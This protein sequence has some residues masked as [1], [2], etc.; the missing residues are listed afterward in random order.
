MFVAS[1]GKTLAMMENN[2]VL[3]LYSTESGKEIKQFTAAQNQN[4]GYL[5][6]VSPDGRR[7][8][9]TGYGPVHVWDVP[10]GAELWKPDGNNNQQMLQNVFSPDG[11]TLACVTGNQVRILEIVSRQERLHIERPHDNPNQPFF[12]AALSFSPD[13]AV[14][15][16]AMQTGEVYLHDVATGKELAKF[17]GHTGAVN[18]L[19]FSPDGKLLA[20]GGGDATVVVWD[21]ASPIKK[22]RPEITGPKDAEMASLWQDLTGEGAKAHH[23]LWAMTVEPKKSV[24]AIKEKLQPGPPADP[25]RVTKLIADLDNEDFDTREKASEALAG[26]PDAEP[27]LKKALENNPSVEKKRRIEALLENRKPGVVGADQIRE[28]RAVEALEMIGTGEAK[29]LLEKLAKGSE[30]ATLTQECKAALDRLG[31][32][33][34]GNR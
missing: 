23:L 28:A 25:K 19:A 3:H 20:S 11:K 26:I 2:R 14:I 29:Q 32:R 18:A 31:K 8:A 15:A 30:D 10:S 1:D 27:E 24:E 5:V 33:D 17:K 9:A 34:G 16:V 21:A 7:V 22:N 12:P 6:V 4:F 13:G